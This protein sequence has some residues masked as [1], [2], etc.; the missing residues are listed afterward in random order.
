MCKLKEDLRKI[1]RVFLLYKKLSSRAH[2]FREKTPKRHN[3]TEK[4]ALQYIYI[5]IKMKYRN[6]GNAKK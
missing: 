2:F 6:V 1:T 5:Y 4:I 3:Y